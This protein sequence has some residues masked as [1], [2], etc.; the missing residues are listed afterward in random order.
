[1]IGTDHQTVRRAGDGVL[2][3]HAHP[4]LGVAQYEIHR[5]RVL[6]FKRRHFTG[7]RLHRRADIYGMALVRRDEIHRGLGVV[8]VK[9]GFVRQTHGDEFVAVV[10]GLVTQLAHRPLGQQAGGQ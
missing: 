5:H 6:A 3:N 4:R 8:F 10:A 9:L 1:M 7:Q 2:S